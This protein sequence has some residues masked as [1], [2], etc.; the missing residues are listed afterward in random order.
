MEAQTKDGKEGSVKYK[1]KRGD[2][3]LATGDKVA[4]SDSLNPTH[5]R[6]PYGTQY[7]TFFFLFG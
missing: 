4:K 7:L 3:R 2:D 6:S 1:C 5:V